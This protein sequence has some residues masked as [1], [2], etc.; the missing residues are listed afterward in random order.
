SH[1]PLHCTASGKLFLAQMEPARRDA[2]I[3]QLLLT[4]MTGTTL[5]TAKALREECAQIAGQGYSCD[6]E[7]FIAGLIAVAV[8][9]HDRDGVVRAALAVHAPSVR[10]SLDDALA[11]LAALRTAAARMH[12]LM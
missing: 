7:E 12:V 6:R 2:L 5:T 1:V 3:A 10:M 9:V 4:R 11:Q 8:P